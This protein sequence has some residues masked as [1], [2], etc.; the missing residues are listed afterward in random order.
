[1]VGN[2]TKKRNRIEIEKGPAPNWAGLYRTRGR[3]ARG[4]R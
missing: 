4:T 2:E 1:M 3:A